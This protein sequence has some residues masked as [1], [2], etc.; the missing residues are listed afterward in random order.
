M[1]LKDSFDRD[2]NNVFLNTTEFADVI[3]IDG[4]QYSCIVYEDEFTHETAIS[5]QFDGVF[6]QRTH[7]LIASSAIKTIPVDGQRIKLKNKNFYVDGVQNEYGIIHL[8][9]AATQS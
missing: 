2:V 8:I 3:K 5:K 6:I 1:T 4:V 9:L 7:V